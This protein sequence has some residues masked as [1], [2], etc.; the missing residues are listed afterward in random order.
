MLRDATH[1]IRHIVLK[2]VM[3]VVD[4]SGDD[5]A[6]IDSV[7]ETIAQAVVTGHANQTFRDAFIARQ[8]YISINQDLL[9]SLLPININDIAHVLLDISKDVQTAALANVVGAITGQQ[10]WKDVLETAVNH[11]GNLSWKTVAL[12]LIARF[13][14]DVKCHRSYLARSRMIEPEYDS[15]CEIL[16]TWDEEPSKDELKKEITGTVGSMF[17]DS[18]PL[19]V[20]NPYQGQSTQQLAAATDELAQLRNE[21]EINRQMS[22]QERQRSAAV[23]NGL[24]AEVERLQDA[25]NRSQ[26]QVLL[27]QSR[28]MHPMS[29]TPSFSSEQQ[30]FASTQFNALTLN[31]SAAMTDKAVLTQQLAHMKQDLD[32]QTAQVTKLSSTIMQLSVEKEALSRKYESV[33]NDIKAKDY[34]INS[35]DSDLNNLQSQV[36]TLEEE[37]N[38]YNAEKNDIA[39][40]RD[41][42]VKNYEAQLDEIRRDAEHNQRLLQDCQ[43]ENDKLKGNAMQVSPIHSPAQSPEQSRTLVTI[44]STDEDEEQPRGVPRRP[45]PL[46][47]LE[48]PQVV[49]Q[50]ACGRIFNTLQELKRH[51]EACTSIVCFR[52]NETFYGE[53]GRAQYKKHMATR[54]RQHVR[55]SS[56]DNDRSS[57]EDYVP[58]DACIGS[59]LDDVHHTVQQYTNVR[60]AKSENEIVSFTRSIAV[61]AQNHRREMMLAERR[62]ARNEQ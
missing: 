38:R 5:T 24:R 28:Q 50:C 61:S 27:L 44:E 13:A 17:S 7:I 23:E 48:H 37:V 14:V 2:S 62:K 33:Q 25:V 8:R 21:L 40:Q 11:T 30:R 32:N 53:N 59:S 52:C 18:Q 45:P 57:D 20:D 1:T 29:S 16:G 22:D 15:I 6:I 35:A 41:A 47:R 43:K 58:S 19:V 9:D 31:L 49:H 60:S 36:K 42:D 55:F 54:H 46:D 12:Y 51:R 3:Q 56:D 4:R 34:R 39:K 26:A 10:S